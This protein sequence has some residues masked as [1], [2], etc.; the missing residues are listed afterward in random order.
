LAALKE[1]MSM[2]DREPMA[3]RRFG[4]VGEHRPDFVK[5]FGAYFRAAYDPEN[6]VLE[7]RIRVLVYLAVLASVGAVDGFQTH[8]R[9]AHAA[10]L[11]EAE[12]LEAVLTA[13]PAVGYPRVMDVMEVLSGY[14]ELESV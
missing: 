11:S 8:L 7:K 12:V 1:T 10:G 4:Y 5:A 13:V 9:D 6:P 3:K 2:S 14:S